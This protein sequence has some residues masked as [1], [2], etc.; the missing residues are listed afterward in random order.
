MLFGYHLP[1]FGY[2]HFVICIHNVAG[3]RCFNGRPATGTENN[4]DAYHEINPF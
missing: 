3:L 1:F 2:S 4:K